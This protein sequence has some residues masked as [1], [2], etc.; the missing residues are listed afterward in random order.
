[1]TIAGRVAPA[2]RRSESLRALLTPE[3]GPFVLLL[4]AATAFYVAPWP[5]LYGP[6]LV[7][8]AA[9]TWRRPELALGLIVAF[10]PL[11]MVP[12]HL[13][14]KEF[15][16][17]E[18][19]LLVDILVAAVYAALPSRRQLLHWDRLLRSPVLPPL[20][21]FVLAGTISTLLATDHAEG[22]RA[23]REVI[24]EPSIFFALLLLQASRAWHWQLLA[25]TLVLTGLALALVSLGQLATHQNVSVVP[26]TSIERVKAFYGSPDN[27]GLFFDRVIPAW[28]ALLVL[29]RLATRWRWAWIGMGPLFALVLFLTGSRGAWIATGLGCLLVLALTFP[30]GRWLALL[31][32]VLGG[33]GL[34]F[35]GH[36]ISRT[37]GSGHANTAERRID[38]WRSSLRMVRDHP[39]TG[40]GPDNFLHYYAPRTGPYLPCK[41]GLGYME[42]AASAEPCLSH[43]HD[44]ILDYWLSTGI[45]GLMAFVWL[46]VVFWRLSARAW[47]RWRAVPQ[48]A[49]ILGAMGAMVATLA[50]G[51]VDNSY[52]LIDLAIVFW[53]LLGLVS[54]FATAEKH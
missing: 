31:C 46:Q 6:A 42:S 21:L 3:L 1:M 40:V 4:L 18:I 38:L 22:F 39:L 47:Q 52:F 32:L 9:L 51:L 25:T 28:L 17:S 29:G 54:F 35:E 7:A 8:V 48:A 49:L 23:F 5:V 16:P 36:A 13:G 14:S 19:F 45:L 27:L 41:H 43:P 2:A 15:A 10:A 26:G 11:F 12:K 34:A 33:I 30:W 53:L 20:L 50:H 44:V 24:A 37:V